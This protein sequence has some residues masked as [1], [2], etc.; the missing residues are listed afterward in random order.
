MIKLQKKFTRYFNGNDNDKNSLINN[1][2]RYIYVDNSGIIWIGTRHGLD[3]FDKK[4]GE[5]TNYDDLL[6]DNGIKD[7]YISSIYEDSDGVLWLGCG[8]E[9]D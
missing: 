3:S 4:K 9:G 5:F 7:Q 2:V 6:S 8:V 1:E